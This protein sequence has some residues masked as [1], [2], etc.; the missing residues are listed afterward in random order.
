MIKTLLIGI[1]IINYDLSELNNIKRYFV[2]NNMNDY[3]FKPILFQSSDKKL[4]LISQ[5]P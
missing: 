5:I 3:F 2:Y 4:V 1:I